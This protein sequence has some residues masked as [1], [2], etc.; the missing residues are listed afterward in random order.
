MDGLGRSGLGTTVSTL[1]T[2]SLL[3]SGLLIVT[4]ATQVV[5]SQR[6]AELRRA[7]EVAAASTEALQAFVYRDA[8]T[9]STLL[10]LRNTGKEGLEVTDVFAVDRGGVVV[11][12]LRL[13]ETIKLGPQQSLTTPLSRIFG[14]EFDSYDAVKDRI[15]SFYFKTFRGRVFGSMYLAPPSIE[16]AAYSTSMVYSTSVRTSE[17]W[18][19][20]PNITETITTRV[21]TVIVDNPSHWP[22][23]V[24]V[25]VTGGGW[26]PLRDGFPEWGLHGDVVNVKIP[27]NVACYSYGEY[28]YHL[29]WN[30]GAYIDYKYFGK[31]MYWTPGPVIR[32]TDLGPMWVAAEYWTDCNYLICSN[33]LFL[34]HTSVVNRVDQTYTTTYVYSYTTTVT[35]TTTRL[36][37]TYTTTY[38]SVVRST[39][40]ATTSG[41][42]LYIATFPGQL[43]YLALNYRKNSCAYDSTLYSATYSLAYVKVVDLWNT[44][45]VLALLTNGN[46]RVKIDRPVGIAAVYTLT[47]VYV[48]PTGPAAPYTVVC[49]NWVGVCASS[50]AE[51]KY[52]IIGGTIFPCNQTTTQVTIMTTDPSNC[53]AFAL[54]TGM[55]PGTYDYSQVAPYT[56]PKSG[57]TITCTAEAGQ[58]I[59]IDC[60]KNE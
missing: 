8:N 33:E 49:S 34:P 50:D 5:F 17:E 30:P 39:S 19:E 12:S 20:I 40:V 6:V 36:L 2:I 18:L 59:I 52:Q 48:P 21:V 27:S 24:Y 25:G 56:C 55:P 22:V 15:A 14:P 37:G 26:V 43:T 51:G 53:D 31:W 41:D 35:T 7:G 32:L 54:P 29:P 57:N 44:S 13:N 11:K 9:N 23:E 47:S 46:L 16:I 38:T 1:L 45:N 4:F 58:T 3:V 42:Y 60:N 10:S 28:R